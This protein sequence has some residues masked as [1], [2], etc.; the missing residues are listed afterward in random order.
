LKEAFLSL[1][2]VESYFFKFSRD[3]ISIEIKDEELNLS[4]KVNLIKNKI[5]MYKHLIISQ[6]LLTFVGN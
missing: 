6:K 1:F 5:K 3:E 4:K 2:W